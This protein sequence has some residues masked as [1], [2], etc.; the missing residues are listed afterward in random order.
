MVFGCF[1]H[2]TLLLQSLTQ[3]F[4]PYFLVTGAASAPAAPLGKRE[5]GVAAPAAPVLPAPLPVTHGRQELSSW[6]TVGEEASTAVA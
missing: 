1:N 2:V 3:S 6:S 4:S 5:T